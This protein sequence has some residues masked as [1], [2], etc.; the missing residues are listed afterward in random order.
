MF[1]RKDAKKKAK[2][3]LKKHYVIFVIACLIA[4][5]IGAEYAESTSFIKGGNDELTIAENDESDVLFDLV[6][7]GLTSGQEAVSK[8]VVIDTSFGPL[9]LGHTKGVLASVVKNVTT[10]SF[11]VIIYKAIS[12]LIKRGSDIFASIGVITAALFLSLVAIFIR[13]VY[14]VIFRR[15][16]LEGYQYDT[17]KSNRFLYIFKCHKWFN[18][19]WCIFKMEIY[20]YLWYLTIIGGIIKTFSYAMVPYIVAE[21]P[22]IKS[23]DAI[24]LSRKIMDGHKWEYF[25]YMLTFIGW[26]LL[27]GLTLGLSGVIFSNPYLEAFNV[28]Y[29]AYL[30]KLAIDNKIDGYENLN[31]TY[32][33]EYADDDTLKN[34]YS[35]L[36]KVKG[37]KPLYPT[38][39]KL[40]GFFATKL[41]VVWKYNDKSN[42]YNKALFDEALAKHYDDIFNR[43]TYPEKLTKQH[44]S[45]K[46]KKDT[47]TLANR[48]YS[49]ST[50]IIIFFALSFIGWLWEVSL[51]LVNEGKFVNRGVLTGPWLPVYGSGILLILILLYHF[52]KSVVEEF[53]S[54]IV[55]CG[56]VEYYTSVYLELTHNGT[57]WW[58]YSGYFL[59]LNGRICAEGLLVFGLGGCIAVY[60]LA[61]M[62]DN[63]L[64]KVNPK[65][66][67]IVCI[68]LI[69]C[70]STDVIHSKKHPNIGEGITSKTIVYRNEDIC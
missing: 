64:R 9:Q 12:T 44:V 54:A 53:V 5:F 25:K 41:G 11:L 10:G 17:V 13:D 68:I 26:W 52:R 30:R 20:L 8:K 29:Y 38:Y 66:L 46:A 63:K 70:F 3:K 56:F 16:F 49:V 67:R 21:N 36:E 61:P 28:E 45:E 42:Q 62:I 33:Y 69:L 31:D 19:A 14:K 39:G 22:S 1:D 50:L 51:H 15:I 60:F 48:Q 47:I 35:D 23:G 2:Q 7:K 32:L 55:L 34:A 43:K 18:S 57:R 6:T 24:T 37:V 40:E 4:S 65:I 27:D 59:N 58:N